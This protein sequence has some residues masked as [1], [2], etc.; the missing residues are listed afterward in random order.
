MAATGRIDRTQLRHMLAVRLMLMRID[1]PDRAHFGGRVWDLRRIDKSGRCRRDIP[2]EFL[3][4]IAICKR[5]ISFRSSRRKSSCTSNAPAVI[6][7]LRWSSRPVMAA[8]S[9]VRLSSSRAT[10]LASAS[11]LMT[12]AA[13][14]EPWPSSAAH[15]DARF[16]IVPLVPN[17][18]TGFNAAMLSQSGVSSRSYWLMSDFRSAG[19]IGS[20]IHQLRRQCAKRQACALQ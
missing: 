3:R 17:A 2:P 20:R 16:S 12:P 4:G 7:S 14:S 6:W 5:E 1:E 15:M 9:L 18:E 11:R 8:R 13:R 19:L 10:S